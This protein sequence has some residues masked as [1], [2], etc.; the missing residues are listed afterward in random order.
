MEEEDGGWWR[1]VG[2]AEGTKQGTGTPTVDYYQVSGQKIQI[3]PE[4]PYIHYVLALRTSTTSL[5]RTYTAYIYCVL[6]LRTCSAYLL[7]IYATYLLCIYTAYSHCV[8]IL[9]TCT[10]YL[11]CVL[12][13]RARCVHILRTCCVLL[14]TLRAYLHYILIR[15]H[16]VPILQLHHCTFG[17]GQFEFWPDT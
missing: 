8:L 17:R 5:L 2:G 15:L 9:G 14:Y 7:R 6:K 4:K 12:A 16:C 11:H 3:E 1:R 10:A 13:L